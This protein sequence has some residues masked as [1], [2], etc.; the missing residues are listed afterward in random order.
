MIDPDIFMSMT[1]KYCKDHY[2]L[3]KQS[4][5][6]KLLLTYC[7]ET[8]AVNDG[9]ST[10]EAEAQ[11]KL[12]VYRCEGC[13]QHFPMDDITYRKGDHG[14]TPLCQTCA[15]DPKFYCF[16][17]YADRLAAGLVSDEEIKNWNAFHDM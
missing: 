2:A 10:E 11:F 8:C 6:R 12:D 4:F 3:R 5:Q 13:Q 9:M 15:D 14:Y 16:F 1:C 7:T 17:P